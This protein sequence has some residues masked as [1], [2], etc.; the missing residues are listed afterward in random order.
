MK[1][2]YDALHR[3]Y[4]DIQSQYAQVERSL[5]KYVP[6]LVARARAA[7]HLRRAQHAITAFGEHHLSKLFPKETR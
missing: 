3:D 2:D 7:A 5:W 1:A 6:E 4:P